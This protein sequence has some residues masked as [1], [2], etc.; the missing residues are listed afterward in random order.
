MTTSVVQGD[1]RITKNDNKFSELSAHKSHIFVF[2]GHL[3]DLAHFMRCF[4]CNKIY[5]H[6]LLV[7]IALVLKRRKW[8]FKH[9]N[10]MVHS[11]KIVCRTNNYIN[12]HKFKH[13]LLTC[14]QKWAKLE[15]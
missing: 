14:Q 6:S 3:F 9:L 10:D 2:L 11:L 13:V 7:I 12:F 5:L 15:I 1:Y 4:F 8:T